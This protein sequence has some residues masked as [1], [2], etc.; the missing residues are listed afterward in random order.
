MLSSCECIKARRAVTAFD[1][2]IPCVVCFFPGL[3]VPS[4]SFSSSLFF[5]SK[6]LCTSF[7]LWGSQS[8]ATGELYTCR[9]I[10]MSS[11]RGRGMRATA[12]CHNMDGVGCFLVCAQA[13]VAS[14]WASLLRLFDRW[15]LSSLRGSVL[16]K[17]VVPFSLPF[18]YILLKYIHQH[19][20]PLIAGECL[21]D[22]FINFVYCCTGLLG[23]S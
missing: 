12:C 14:T 9:I 4:A 19:F 15:L 5:S 10:C 18:L 6:W 16:C 3:T 20:F 23:C 2:S 1:D 8:G 13:I 7:R 21:A 11:V 22:I 17:C